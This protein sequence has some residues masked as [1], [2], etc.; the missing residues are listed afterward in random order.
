MNPAPRSWIAEANLEDADYPLAHLPY[1]VFSH[2]PHKPAPRPGVA[3]GS[4]IL[5]LAA[6]ARH[7]RLAGR[8]GALDRGG[9]EPALNALMALGSAAW[10]ALRARLTDLLSENGPGA[11]ALARLP[12]A[13]TPLA[14]AVLHPPALIRGYTD[15]YAS[16]HHA[17][18]VGRLFRPDQP[19]MP[20]YKWVPIGY[21]G[22]A[23]SLV[24]SGVPVVRPCGQLPG[25]PGQPPSF[26]ASRALDFELEAAFF[27]GPGNAL[28]C[29][30]PISEAGARIFGVCLL[31]D[32]SARDIQ[33]WEYQPL[34]PFLGKNFATSISSWVVTMEALEPYRVPPPP[35]AAGDPAPLPYLFDEE[36]QR[37][38]A[39][40]AVLEVHILSARMRASGVAPLLICRS[41]LRHLYWTPA[42]LLA[43]HT[44]N[45]CNLE[46]GDLLATGT[47]SGPAPDARGCLL[48]I[49]AGGSPLALPTGESRAWLEDG[50]EVTL[51]GYCQRAG[52]PRISLG[53]CRGT[54][55]GALP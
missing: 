16:I 10:S 6:A 34:G 2:P 3:L 26:G 55:T 54:V 35:R 29:S 17:E 43:H 5:A 46:P 48:E 8:G 7:G 27:S 30:V 25:P 42:Q 31:N 41:N 52:L 45:G 53:R 50:D 20:N 49:A 24:L 4:R 47:V 19:L 14:D 22:R 51:S 12:D 44:S 40:D 23:S 15:F 11:A 18:N 21:H 33:R 39:I 38:G 9:R 13:F 37:R 1:G 36:D 32:W 28:G